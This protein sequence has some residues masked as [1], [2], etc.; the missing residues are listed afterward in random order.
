MKATDHKN[1]VDAYNEGA[2]VNPHDVGYVIA[3]LSLRAPLSLTGQFVRWDNEE[4]R[5][6]RRK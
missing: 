3:A 2:L 1:F 4:C 6:F 5:E